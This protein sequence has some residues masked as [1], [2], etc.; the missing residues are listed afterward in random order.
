MEKSVFINLCDALRIR[1]LVIAFASSNDLYH[2]FSVATKN[3]ETQTSMW[4]SFSVEV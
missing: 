3:K 4:F 2:T 1:W